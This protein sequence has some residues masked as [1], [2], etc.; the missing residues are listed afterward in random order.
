MKKTSINKEKSLGVRFPE[1]AKQWA[2]DLN[3]DLTPFHILPYTS[4]EYY[5]RCE[6]DSNHV[7]KASVKSRVVNGPRCRFCRKEEYALRS[8][9]AP[10]KERLDT[11]NL[12]FLYPEIAEEWD[13]EKNF[14][15]PDKVFA[16]SPIKYHWKC[17]KCG[18]LWTAKVSNRTG[19][20]SG[21]PNCYI[22]TSKLLNTHPDVAARWHP[23]KNKNLWPI[24]V[25]A[26]D[27]TE[28]YWLCPH[29]GKAYKRA[30][31]NM[32]KDSYCPH[33]EA[34]KLPEIE[35]ERSLAYQYPEVANQLHPTLNP[36]NLTPGQIRPKSSRKLWWQ[37]LEDPNHPPWQALVHNRTAGNQG[38]PICA[39]LKR[40]KAHRN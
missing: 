34:K 31:A 24:D 4:E 1:I 29:C 19:K 30:I 7:W 13:L 22:E 39:R 6:K 40:S 17:K 36:P 28:I 38:C 8:E 26:S 2:Q 37:C 33:C 11:S 10:R 12:Q 14:I 9:R 5:W 27:T 25:A 35:Y 18:H 32:V 15:T 20:N 3:D 16:G 21:C 23:T